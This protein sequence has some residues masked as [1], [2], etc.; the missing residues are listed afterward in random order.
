MNSR[1]PRGLHRK[2]PPILA[3]LSILLA[4]GIIASIVIAARN[5][6]ARSFQEKVDDSDYGNFTL[7]YSSPATSE[8]LG[9]PLYPGADLERSFVY[10]AKE[11]DGEGSGYLAQAFLITPDRAEK[12]AEF[13]KAQLGRKVS[14]DPKPKKDEIF[15]FSELE[16]DTLTV[17]IVSRRE[18]GKT[19]IMLSRAH[20]RE[21]TR[22][23]P[24][25]E[26]KPRRPRRR[27]PPPKAPVEEANQPL[28]RT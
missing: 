5:S 3:L 24:P 22:K 19:R 2:A 18:N 1:N 6:E 28:S 4:L 15:L 14:I 13:Y 17:R 9:M 7:D 25:Q 12:V 27:P 23:E 10:S 26:E 20:L 21:I 16:D 8:D 11:Q